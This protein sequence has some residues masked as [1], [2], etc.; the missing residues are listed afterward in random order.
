MTLAKIENLTVS[1]RKTVKAPVEK[2]F[3]AWTEANQMVKWFGCGRVA[4]VQVSQDFRVGGDYRITGDEKSGGAFAI[5][6]TYEEIVQ[7]KKVVYTWNNESVE[8]PARDTVVSVEF[9][10]R[11]DSTEILV[12]HTKFASENAKQGH[13]AGWTQSLEIFA[14]YVAA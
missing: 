5:Y 12:E 3:K 11:G 9:I 6:G 2:A 10:A 7:N 8:F 14:N 1:V 13:N 4:N